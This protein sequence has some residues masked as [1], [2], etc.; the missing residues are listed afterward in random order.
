MTG[1]FIF[2]LLQNSK[3]VKNSGSVVLEIDFGIVCLVHV[4]E[5]G[6]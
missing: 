1:C 6:A 3:Q 2:S 4:H 5:R